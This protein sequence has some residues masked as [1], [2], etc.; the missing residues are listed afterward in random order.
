M[1]VLKVEKINTYINRIVRL[2]EQL[3]AE[4]VMIFRGQSDSS[5]GLSSALCRNNLQN[6]EKEMYERAL[7]ENP[8]EFRFDSIFEKLVKMQHYGMPTRLLDVTFNPLVA[9]YFAI[10]DDR[11]SDAI[12]YCGSCAYDNDIE[13]WGN[14]LKISD[15]GKC[16]DSGEVKLVVPPKNN[17]RI[18]RQNG[19]FL[20]SK[21]KTD[22]KVT[23]DDFFTLDKIVIQKS[24]KSEIR[25]QLSLMGVNEAFLFPELQYQLKQIKEMYEYKNI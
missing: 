25:R 12:V 14:V 22:A 21:K 13:D 4:N 19:A 8:D 18:H 2:Y 9:L 7:I 16:T 11:N 24:R 1:G 17:S 3:D 15:L 23:Y 5:W 6:Y 20:I 10:C